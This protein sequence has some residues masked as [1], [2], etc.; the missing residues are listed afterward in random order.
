MYL[1]ISHFTEHHLSGMGLGNFKWRVCDLGLC[2]VVNFT[3]IPTADTS[4]KLNHVD[5]IEP[6]DLV[7]AGPLCR[8][9]LLDIVGMWNE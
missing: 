3:E 8:F 2:Q 7:Q 5:F 1:F 4:T 9:L 6:L